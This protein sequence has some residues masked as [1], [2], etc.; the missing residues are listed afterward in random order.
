MLWCLACE[1]GGSDILQLSVARA[2][3]NCTSLDPDMYRDAGIA[4]LLVNAGALPLLVPHL[5]PKTRLP[6]THAS[7]FARHCSEKRCVEV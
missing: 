3:A 1:S 7:H 4:Q 5:A 2:L 6:R